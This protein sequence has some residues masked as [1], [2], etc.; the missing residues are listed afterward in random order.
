MPATIVSA[1]AVQAIP[2]STVVVTTN[3]G[4][5]DISDPTP[6]R[7]TKARCSGSSRTAVV[8][9]YGIAHS[10][11][12]APV[13]THRPIRRERRLWIGDGSTGRIG[14]LVNQ[15]TSV[16]TAAWLQTVG[17]ATSPRRSTFC[18]ERL[19][20]SIAGRFRPRHLAVPRHPDSAST[21]C[22]RMPTD[23]SQYPSQG[24]LFE[25]GRRQ[26]LSRRAPLSL[27]DLSHDPYPR[28]F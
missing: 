11:A 28:R 1:T 19:A 9:V 27:L 18:S 14:S 16:N 21:A 6:L 10:Q 13:S 12:S 20:A 2:A 5:C 3:V 24:G 15:A 4:Y 7:P 23:P 17:T 22:R 8:V 26:R 25:R